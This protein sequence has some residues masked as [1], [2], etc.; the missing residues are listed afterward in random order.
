MRAVGETGLDHFRTGEELFGTLARSAP[1]FG[2]IGTILGLVEML[3]AHAGREDNLLYRWAD[4]R[5]DAALIAAARRHV[6]TH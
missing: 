6:G 3:R 5:L 2:L 4:E 1:A